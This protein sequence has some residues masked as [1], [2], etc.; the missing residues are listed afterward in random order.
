MFKIKPSFY[1]CLGGHEWLLHSIKK[2]YTMNYKLRMTDKQQKDYVAMMVRES[3][4][5]SDD[6]SELNESNRRWD[7]QN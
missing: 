1:S 2:Y 3:D 5:E 7:S 4:V 6:V